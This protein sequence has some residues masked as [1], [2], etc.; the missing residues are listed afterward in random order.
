MDLPIAR[1]N[2]IASNQS[3]RSCV[4]VLYWCSRSIVFG[5]G[6]T[7]MSQALQP[8]GEQSRILVSKVG[9]KL[10]ASSCCGAHSTSFR[11]ACITC[12]GA[13]PCTQEPNAACASFGG[14]VGGQ[15]V[16]RHLF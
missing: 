3:S 16:I 14:V 10:G 11:L 6:R 4:A 8:T 5:L 13:R 9:S 12:V 2:G 7:R 1:A 15:F